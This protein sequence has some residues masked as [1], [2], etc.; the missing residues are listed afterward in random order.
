M[1]R[2]GWVPRI[3]PGTAVLLAGVAV[4]VPGTFGVVL[5]NQLNRARRAKFLPRP[6]YAIDVQVEPPW[7]SGP[8]LRVA[9]LGDSLVEGVGAPRPGQSLP[10]QTAYRL[11]AHLGRPVHMR[12]YGI[13]SSRIAQVL[14]Q[15]V[16]LLTEDV[17][18]VV[19]L[20]GANDAAH[21]TPPWDFAR[22]VE[23]LARDAHDRTGGAPVV[24]TGLP[25]L[26][27]APLL[28]WPL[29]GVAGAIGD[30][31][32]AIQR[33]LALRL[34]EARYIDMRCEVGHT[35]RSRARE[36]FADDRYHPNPTGYALL[37]EA[38]ARS[39]TS[40]LQGEDAPQHE[41]ATEAERQQIHADALAELSS[42]PGMPQARDAQAA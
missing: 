20:V 8:P 3:P 1:A 31:L 34:P 14:A 18:L 37:G 10:A 42:L 30:T 41:A 17:D 11:A 15:Q 12:G 23:T 19:V 7:V 38:I 21:G 26:D 24:F 16:P 40:M 33:R 13:A 25:H 35:F 28:S 39:L 5:G 6:G 32:H 2:I 36:L 22:A 4:G 27:A 29:R 9:F